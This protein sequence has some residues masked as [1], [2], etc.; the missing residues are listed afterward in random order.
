MAVASHSRFLTHARPGGY[1]C[2]SVVGRD[3]RIVQ[4]GTG[5]RVHLCCVCVSVL[6]KERR[7]EANRVESP[8]GLG[9]DQVL[10]PGRTWI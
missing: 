4:L 5:G 6:D 3:S 10:Y 7:V 1:G 2:A 9:I 8:E